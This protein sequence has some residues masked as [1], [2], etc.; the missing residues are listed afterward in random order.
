MSQVSSPPNRRLRRAALALCCALIGAMPAAASAES[1]EQVTRGAGAQGWAPFYGQNVPIAVSDDGRLAA[2]TSGGQQ[3]PVLYVR[4]IVA[5]TTT[6][7]GAPNAYTA[8]GFDTALRQVL[9][10]RHTGPGI[11]FRLDLVPTN[12]GAATP[13]ATF[14]DGNVSAALSGDGK[15]V[16]YVAGCK[17]KIYSVATGNQTTLDVPG[18]PTFNPRSL[19]DNGKVIAVGASTGGYYFTGGQRYATPSTP[20]VSP[21]GAIVAWTGYDAPTGKTTITGKRLADGVTRTVLA[22]DALPY[23]SITWISP[24]GYRVVLSTGSFPTG[25]SAQVVNLA[26]GTWSAFGGPFGKEVALDLTTANLGPYL[27]GASAISRNGKYG[28]VSIG[29]PQHHLAVA[30]LTGGD[31]PGTQEAP[32][33]SAYAGNVGWYIEC[34]QP[35][36]AFGDFAELPSWIANPRRATF[37]VSAN[38][39]VVK[40]LTYSGQG[41]FGP[42][43]TNATLPTGT[44][45]ITF[46]AQVTD[47]AGRSLTNTETLP[48]TCVT[49]S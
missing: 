24:D 25:G 17:A 9:I 14:P 39:R 36:I 10:L 38:G 29:G 37:T 26:T 12:G 41:T 28:L 2:F 19:S 44:T 20:V 13:I 6:L 7:L 1:F 47:A 32:S 5:N 3:E 42:S 48:V 23:G 35:G 43:Y 33:A 16:A 21:D 46:S 27:P 15:T 8:F 18:C 49:P 4:D 40:T 31:L 30:N 45:K 11:T 34:G 22:S